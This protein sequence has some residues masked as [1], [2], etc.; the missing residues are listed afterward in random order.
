MDIALGISILFAPLRAV[1]LYMGFWAVFTALLRPAAG[2][3]WW[4]FLERAGNYGA[5]LALLFLSGTCPK[6]KDWFKVLPDPVL[7]QRRVATLALY[8]RLFIALLLIGHGGYGAFQQ[9]EMLVGH[10][11]SVHVPP[12]GWMN[13]AEFIRYFGWAEIF[14]GVLIF[15]K[16]WRWLC[17]FIVFWKLSTEFLYV[18]HGP[19][20]WDVFEFI[21]RWG[22]YGVPL[23]LYFLLSRK[24]ERQE[25]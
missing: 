21:E 1:M 7:D 25:L 5:P 15:L 17:L 19:V 13:G 11:A 16:P 14:L 6:L 3:G 24:Q 10:F 2:M 12:Q 23:A 22:S 9:K 8:L 18:V 4:E 20:L